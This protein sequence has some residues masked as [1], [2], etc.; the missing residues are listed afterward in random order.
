[1]YPIDRKREIMMFLNNLSNSVLKLCNSRKLSYE[2]ASEQC[3]ISSRYFG[4]IARGKTAPTILT[5]EKI[6]VG[7]DLTPN[8]LLIS[9]SVLKE[10]AFRNSMPVTNVC[11]F[12]CSNGISTFPVCPK[13]GITLE[14]E[15]QPFCD[16]CGQCLNW[17]SFSE[18]D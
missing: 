10:L 9:T 17:K 1:M 14:R 8:D 11:Y 18:I 3:N 15:Y 6:C 12:R 13:C 2:A 4:D 16:R 5:L 7:F